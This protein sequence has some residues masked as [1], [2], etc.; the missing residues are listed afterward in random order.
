[1]RWLRRYF[2]GKYLPTEAIGTREVTESSNIGLSAKIEAV[3]ENGVNEPGSP[4][5]VGSEA[6]PDEKRQPTDEP[7]VVNCLYVLPPTACIYPRTACTYSPHTV[8]TCTRAGPQSH[9]VVVAAPTAIL[10]LII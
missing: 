3:P 6:I 2:S 4:D 5:L 10:L 9:L 7:Q 8:C 1:M